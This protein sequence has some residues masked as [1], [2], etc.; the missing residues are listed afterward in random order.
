MVSF[1][2]QFHAEIVRRCRKH[3][4]YAPNN[5]QNAEVDNT[6]GREFKETYDASEAFATASEIQTVM[7][8]EAF[9]KEETT[10]GN[11]KY[12]SEICSSA[13]RGKSVRIYCFF[14]FFI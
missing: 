1:Q 7:Y 2:E 13:L 9:K 5:K 12:V 4:S 11:G 6:R 10:V 3:L 14:V 8:K